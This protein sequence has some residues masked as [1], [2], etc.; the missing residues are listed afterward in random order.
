MCISLISWKF[1][2]SENRILSCSYAQPSSMPGTSLGPQNVYWINVQINLSFK[3][4]LTLYNLSM[5]NNTKDASPFSSWTLHVG[6]QTLS[7]PWLS[8]LCEC[9]QISTH[10]PDFSPL[11]TFIFCQLRKISALISFR[12]L[13]LNIPKPNF[14]CCSPSKTAL[15]NFSIS[16]K[17]TI[18]LPVTRVQKKLHGPLSF[19]LPSSLETWIPS[20]SNSC[21]FFMYQVF[22]ICL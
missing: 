13:K 11:N 7:Q 8:A 3:S 21:R 5:T 1:Y 4:L 17:G 12:Y 6:N 10:N 15:P 18:N 16:N 14:S 19:V 2:V 20:V 9:A 22:S